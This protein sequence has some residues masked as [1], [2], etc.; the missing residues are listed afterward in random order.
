M[1]HRQ[2]L[3]P[4]VSC[5]LLTA[6]LRGA[7]APEAPQTELR[8]F[9]PAWRNIGEQTPQ[10]V[11]KRFTVIMGH[12][13]PA[14]FHEG[15]TEAKCLK[16]ILG[17][18]VDQQE[19]ELMKK[20]SPSALAYDAQG[21]VVKARAWV[22][23]LV[24][25]DDPAWLAYVTKRT[26]EL[27][28]SDFDGLFVDSMG[29]APVSENYTN[30]LAI[31]PHTRK[32][33][34]KSEWLAAEGIML[35]AI[36]RAVP[37]GK[38]ITLNG[39][40][41]GARYWTEPESASPR[42]LL[43]YVKGAMSERIW[44]D[45]PQPLDR[46]PTAEHWMEDVRMVQDVERRGL[47]GFWWTKCWTKNG[48]SRHEPNAEVLVPQWRR[49]SLASYLLAA[50]PH[51]YFNFDT[52]RDDK[53]KSNAAEYF[54]EYDAPLGHAISEMIPLGDTGAYARR[55]SNGVVLVNPTAQAILSV[56]LP[57]PELAQTKFFSAGE[58]RTLSGE[59]TLPAHTGL[60]LTLEP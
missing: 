32:P 20:E 7:I 21:G 29:T 1:L 37:P 59:F 15:N 43:P 27:M 56:K 48:T 39:L 57:W 49:F 10:S 28:S 33:Y 4:L 54:P 23:W 6:G 46:W 24:T 11:A 2:T 14:P 44:R 58:S 47:M 22:N 25:P 40:G 17:P 38:L 42:V 45:P 12:L 3:L 34:T 60:L 8:L 41:P 31:N 13:P 5:L 52:D 30:T 50:G 55:F 26:T 9:T 51:S 18:Y 35:D 36:R 16:Y 19:L 53:P